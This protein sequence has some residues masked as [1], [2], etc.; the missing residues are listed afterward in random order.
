MYYHLH[1]LQHINTHI[2]HTPLHTH[3]HIH[4]PLADLF[5]PVSCRHTNIVSQHMIGA[6]WGSLHDVVLLWTLL[7]GL[8]ETPLTSGDTAT[9][10]ER[11]RGGHTGKDIDLWNDVIVLHMLCMIIDCVDSLGYSEHSGAI[12]SVVAPTIA[13][14]QL[15]VITLLIEI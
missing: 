14:I 5:D 6:H 15:L 2:T 3:T 9:Q 4:T 11:R 7:S 10:L 12:E 8:M 1:T 13:E